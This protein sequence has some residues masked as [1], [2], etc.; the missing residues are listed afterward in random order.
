MSSLRV[1]GI[2]ST[3]IAA[4][5]LQTILKILWEWAFISVPIFL[6]RK[7]FNWENNLYKEAFIRHGLPSV[8]LSD[9][10][11]WSKKSPLVVI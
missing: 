1:S 2:I 9:Q 10:N 8:L 3:V 6:E 5:P 4:F 11:G 7:S